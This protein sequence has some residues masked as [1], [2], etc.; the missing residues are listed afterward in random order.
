MPFTST[1]GYREAVASLD[2]TVAYVHTYSF[3]H[4]TFPQ[5][6]RFAIS[7]TDLIIEGVTYKA[8]QINATLPDVTVGGNQGM[9]ITVSNVTSSMINIF[10]TAKN[11]K[12][13]ILVDPKRFVV[14]QPTKTASFDTKL[15]VKNVNFNG[16]DMVLLAGYP[17]STNLKLPKE[18]YTTREC[19]GLRS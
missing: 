1:Q 14:D 12:E 8:K 17:D 3:S 18:K 11:T 10:K 4:S 6:Y 19:P 5:V 16:S 7:D 2:S 15:F 9:N 13:A